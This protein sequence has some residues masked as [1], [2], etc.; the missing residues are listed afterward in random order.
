MQSYEYQ[1]LQES[2]KCDYDT[3]AVEAKLARFTQQ[4]VMCAQRGDAPMQQ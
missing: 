1:M 4:L 2:S 3:H